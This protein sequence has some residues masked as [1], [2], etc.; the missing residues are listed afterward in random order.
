MPQYLAFR[1][2]VMP[3]EGCFVHQMMIVHFT[4]FTNLLIVKLVVG[5][6]QSGGRKGLKWPEK[7]KQSL[8]HN[9]LVGVMKHMNKSCKNN[10]K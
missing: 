4:T 7:I 9:F 6:S 3:S 8:T 10:V 1:K 2:K 5:Y